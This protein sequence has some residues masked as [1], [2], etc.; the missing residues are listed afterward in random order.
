MTCVWSRMPD[1][2]HPFELMPVQYKAGCRDDR[3][4]RG[5]YAFY[6]DNCPNCGEPVT[7]GPPVSE[8]ARHE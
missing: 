8:P 5:R 7:V 2:E 6:P 4:A 1:N 3:I